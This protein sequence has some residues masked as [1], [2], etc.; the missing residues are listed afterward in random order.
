MSDIKNDVILCGVGG[1]GTVLASKLLASAAMD[2][3]LPVKTA[4]TIGMA[5]RGGSVTSHVRIGSGAASPLIGRGGADLIIGFEPAEAVRQLRFLREDGVVVVGN[6]PIV[7]VSATTGGPAYDLE[8]IMAYL[9]ER[10][11]R[12]EVVDVDAAS[13]DLGSTKCLNVVLLGAVLRTGALG[14]SEADVEGAIRRM[15]PARFLDLNLRALRYW[16][17]T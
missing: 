8:G 9:R 15:V 3:G 1:Q 2:R 10:V 4:E 14:F 5:Q 13:R 7:P 17:A 6:R 11:R 12:L 16:Q